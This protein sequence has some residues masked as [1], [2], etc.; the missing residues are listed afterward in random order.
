[1]RLYLL[2]IEDVAQRAVSQLD[3]AGVP[4]CRPVL[5]RMTGEQSKSSK[6]RGGIAEFLGL[7]AGEARNPCLGLDTALDGLMV[8]AYSPPRRCVFPVAQQRPR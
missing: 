3:T 2:L 8:C 4:L 5:T 7:A 6:I 1:M